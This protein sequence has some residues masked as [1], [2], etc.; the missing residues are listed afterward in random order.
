MNYFEYI[1]FKILNK[2]TNY[3]DTLKRKC[4]HTYPNGKSASVVYNEWH[5]VC[6]V[7]GKA[8]PSENMGNSYKDYYRYDGRI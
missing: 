6:K 7:C 4:K 3:Y 2:T 8:L 5:N 1:T